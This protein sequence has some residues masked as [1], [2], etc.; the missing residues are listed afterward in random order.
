M[1]PP[2]PPWRHHFIPE[3]YLSEW[4]SDHDGLL[5]RF[6]RSADGVVRSRRLPPAGLGWHPDLYRA[7]GEYSD[8]WDAQALETDFFSP[9]DNAAQRCM[10]RLNSNDLD[11]WSS[12]Q[13]TEWV[14]FL[15]GLFHRQPEHLAATKVKLREIYGQSVP[16][17]QRRYRQVRG[18][19][20]PLLFEDWER[21]RSL[22]YLDAAAFRL[23]P[24]TIDNKKVG[25]F[26][27]NTQWGVIDLAGSDYPLLMSDNPIIFRPL[28]LDM[29]HIAIPISPYKLFLACEDKHLFAYLKG[30]GPK[31][32][33]RAANHVVV[34]NANTFVGAIDRGSEAYIVKHFGA[35]R[36]GSLATG[37]A[38][39]RS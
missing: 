33:V 27:I 34:G 10:A 38:Q 26:I 29:G 23:L 20:D 21:E 19:D 2:N 32:I 12:Q 37:F 25:E 35:R 39:P 16:D 1:K 13:R 22:G 9:L 7:P 11:A 36:L 6:R 24:S 14:M 4:T 8:P 3:F 5:E 18:P 30:E 17:I 15:L 31:K 28:K